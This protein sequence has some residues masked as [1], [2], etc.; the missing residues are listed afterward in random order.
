MPLTP[1]PDIVLL[2]LDGTIADSYPGILRCLTLALPTIDLG[3]LTEDQIRAFLGPPLHYTLG[4]VYGKSK[5]EIDDFVVV[6]RSHYF[7]GGEYEFEV[8]PG[9]AE[10]IVGLAN[11][12][13]KLGLATAK[14]IP[15]AERVLT[16]AGLI[17]HF[18]FVGGSDMDLT[19]QDKPSILS[20][21]IKNIGGSI[22]EGSNANIVM[23]GDRKEDILGAKHHRLTSIGAMWGYADEGELQDSGPDHIVSN[24]SELRAILLP[25]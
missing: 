4:E 1:S 11:S 9:M 22:A 16:R 23:V 25:E 7:G 2:D 3:H 15:S 13:I 10:L 21:T 20:F 17:D 18:D 6:Y 24:A 14:P 8:F 12:D 5:Q 19:R